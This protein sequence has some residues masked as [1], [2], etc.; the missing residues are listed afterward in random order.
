MKNDVRD[1]LSK[2][3]QI[4][5]EADER[6]DTVDLN[7]KANLY[8]SNE[9]VNIDDQQLAEIKTFLEE[10]VDNVDNRITDFVMTANHNS[11]L[12]RTAIEGNSIK[13]SIDLL[14][15]DNVNEQVTFET[16]GAVKLSAIDKMMALRNYLNPKRIEFLINL[17]K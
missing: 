16:V 5:K 1:S 10:I 8:L 9:G 11:L 13:L 3:R 14:A 12:I 7:G 17:I 4:I 6:N 15:S 2:I